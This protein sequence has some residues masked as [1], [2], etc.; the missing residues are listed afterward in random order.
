MPH[1][2]TGWPPLVTV[3][4]TVT[5]R[6]NHGCHGYRTSRDSVLWVLRCRLVQPSPHPYRAGWTHARLERR[7]GLRARD[8]QFVSLA[9]APSWAVSNT[10]RRMTDRSGGWE[11]FDSRAVSDVRLRFPPLR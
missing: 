11:V 6:P 9:D 3:S 1:R 7:L 10:D 5:R 2:E 8:C 4:Y